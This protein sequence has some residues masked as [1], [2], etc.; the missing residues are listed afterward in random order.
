[1]DHWTYQDSDYWKIWTT[2]LMKANHDTKSTLFN[3]ALVTVERG[4]FVFGRNKFSELVDVPV[5]K[6]RKCLKLLQQ[7]RMI[8]QQNFNKYSIIS[9]RNY[10]QYQDID[11]QSDQQRASTFDENGSDAAKTAPKFDQQEEGCSP[12]DTGCA[13]KNDQQSDQQSA[14]KAPAKDQQRAT[15]KQLKQL[16]NGT[17]NTSENKFTDEDMRLAEWIFDGVKRVA[18]KT[19]KPNFK[20]WADVIRLMRERDDLT[21]REIA[22]MFSF[23]NN[24]NFWSPNILSPGKLREKFAELD[25]KRRARVSAQ[26]DYSGFLNDDGG[27]DA[28]H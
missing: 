16:N 8:D 21:H 19:K 3:G 10:E 11:Q 2:M 4:Q 20:K 25:A 17:N 24:D 14:S 12:D 1:M 22:E 7:D 18:P 27:D 23:A 6:I 9:I 26:P 15:S 28:V 5:H 13:Q